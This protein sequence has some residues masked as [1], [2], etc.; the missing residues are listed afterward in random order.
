MFQYPPPGGARQNFLRDDFH[1]TFIKKEIDD[2][3]DVIFCSEFF[4]LAV[5]FDNFSKFISVEM[6]AC[7]IWGIPQFSQIL[8]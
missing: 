4:I 3:Y 2:A 5:F 1:S 7:Q 8:L 6:A